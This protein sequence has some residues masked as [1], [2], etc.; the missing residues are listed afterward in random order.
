MM[1]HFVLGYTYFDANGNATHG[2][3]SVGTW[4]QLRSIAYATPSRTEI[5]GYTADL[6]SAGWPRRLEFDPRTLSNEFDGE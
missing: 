6:D 1:T 4:E 2:E 3:I 5:V